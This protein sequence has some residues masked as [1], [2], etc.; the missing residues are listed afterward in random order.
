MS[1]LRFIMDI[2]SEMELVDYYPENEE[3]FK[4]SLREN[5]VK[6]DLTRSRILNELKAK[7]C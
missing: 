2:F 6:V 5:S 7:K 1:K 4:Y 3:V